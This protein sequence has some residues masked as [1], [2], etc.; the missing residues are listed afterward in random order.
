MLLRIIDTQ[1]VSYAL[2]GSPIVEGSI[3]GFSITSTVAQEFLRVR[4]V[5]TG[6][7]RYF[8]PPPNGLGPG[9]KDAYVAQQKIHLDRPSDRPLF[10][11][12]TDR[13]IMDFNNEF[14]SVVEY[15]HIGIAHLLN[16][17]NR[18]I[19]G[20]S[21]N[22][23][24]K[25]ERKDL[26]EKFTFLADQGVR[27][28]PVR[29]ESIPAAFDLLK[30]LIKRGF[31]LKSDFRNSL[32][33]MLILGTAIANGADLWTK[34]ELLAQFAEDEGLSK[35]KSCDSHFEITFSASESALRRV[36]RESKGYVNTGWRYSMDRAPVPSTPMKRR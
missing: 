14:P 10:K 22:H 27:C 9:A 31:N 23:L 32:N 6:D 19:F 18:P 11:K 33:D 1:I 25:R 8:T 36:S 34:D 26:L 12:A 21:V 5:A 13:L 3:A 35:V 17:A 2:K 20:E 29:A 30:R 28:I 4:D 15:G 7:A 16:T 24:P